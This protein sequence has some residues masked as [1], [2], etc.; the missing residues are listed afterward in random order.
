MTPT[1][2][3][4][5]HMTPMHTTAQVLRSAC[6]SLAL[7]S[8]SP[9]LDAELL[10]GKVLGIARS[11]LIARDAE[12]VPADTL[13]AYQSLLEQ[14]A[15]GVPVAYLTGTREF[16]SL[17]LKVTPAVLVPRPE[18]EILVE[19]ALQL[20]P[21]HEE[22][23]V[24]DLGTGSGAIALALASERPRAQLTGVDISPSALDVARDNSRALGLSIDWRLG[25]WFDA[26]RGERFDLV[27]ANPPYVAAADRALE[28]LSAE[29]TLALVAGPTGLEA[30][31]AIVAQAAAHLAPKGWLL[32]EHGSLQRNAVVRLFER[33]GISGVRSS[34]D[35]SG[36][37]RVTLGTFHSP[38]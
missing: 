11:A 13:R 1:Q 6:E 9:R 36:L 17:P 32:L 27:V 22:R 19:L 18:T 23:S 26:V 5:M 24:L 4:A 29:P 35:Y 34:D 8:G 37:P 16:W 10:L 2:M 25:S 33:H 28:A 7:H 14:R 15:N 31:G 38:P 30:I 20:L 12:P 21:L 3:T